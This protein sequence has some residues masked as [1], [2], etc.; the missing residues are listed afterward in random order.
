MTY[1]EI[2]IKATTLTTIKVRLKLHEIP[3]GFSTV[4]SMDFPAPSCQLR[5]RSIGPPSCCHTGCGV[6]WPGKI[7]GRWG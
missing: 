2:T 5:C 1:H 6:F 3:M 7:Y 4:P